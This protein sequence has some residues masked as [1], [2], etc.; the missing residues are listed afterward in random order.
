MDRTERYA[1]ILTQVLQEE[2]KVQPSFQPGLKIVSSCDRE[3]GQ[4]L[5]II[6][7]WDRDEWYHSILFHAQLVNDKII[8]EADMT[9]E[10]LKPSLIEAGIREEDFLSDDERDDFFAVRAAA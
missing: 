10:A 1:E 5:L 2:T 6:V 9:E 3:T 8:I 7:G 4:F